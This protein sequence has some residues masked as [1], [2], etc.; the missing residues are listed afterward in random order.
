MDFQIFENIVVAEAEK[1]KGNRR[2]VKRK[3]ITG[4]V[5]RWKTTAPI[6]YTFRE[7]DKKWRQLI[8]EGLKLWERE[9]CLRFKENGAGK[10]RIQFIRGGGCYSSVGRTGGVQKISIGFGCEDKGIV[11]HEVGHS[12]GFWHEQSRPDRDKYIKLEGEYIAGG[13]EGNFAKR[14]DLESDGMGLPYDLGSVMHYGPTAFTLDWDHN[15]IVTKDKRYQHT[16]GQ[17]VGPS[18]IDVKQ[19]NRLYCFKTCAGTK[20]RCENGGYADPNNC[21]QCKCP[22]GL[23]GPHCNQVEKELAL[24]GGELHALENWQ[25]LTHKGKQR[26]VWRIS[27]KK[28][29]IRVILD[30]ASYQCQT[31]CKSFLELKHNSDFQQIGFRSCCDEKNVETLSDQEEIIVIHDPRDQ[32]YDGSFT[33]RYI[34]DSGTP[35]PK[36]PPPAWVPGSENR[37][38]RGVSGKGGVIE[39]F[40]L[41]AIPMVRDPNRPVESVFS[42]FTDYVASSFLGASR[43]K[44]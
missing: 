15:T 24:C 38:F 10:D 5:Y 21:N 36:P 1:K 8:K 9:T 22:P 16:I 12:L 41:N 29:R 4:S 6:P 23:G 31:T 37:A 18:F 33:L 11:S 32:S 44:K 27:A 28:A 35:L 39:K 14:S 19:I 26:C 25:H 43:D 20:V 40:I 17:R 7:D 13:T 3:V 30:K 34:R 2:R 42:I